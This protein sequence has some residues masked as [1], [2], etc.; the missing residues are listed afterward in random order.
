MIRVVEGLW[1]WLTAA[2]VLIGVAAVVARRRLRFWLRVAKALATDQRIPKPLRWGIRAGLMVK[3]LP[4]DFGLDEA[5]LGVCGL[6][7]VTLY[8][9]QALAVIAEVQ[10]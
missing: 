5:V 3:C 8:R 6:L 7:L 9:R 1:P 10:R 2:A 4:L